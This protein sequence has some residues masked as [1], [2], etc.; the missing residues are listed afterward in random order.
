MGAIL[1][2]VDFNGYIIYSKAPFRIDAYIKETINFNQAALPDGIYFLQLI[3]GEKT[4]T[5]KII[6]KR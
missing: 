6:L 4:G 1:E 3:T 5:Q 2:V